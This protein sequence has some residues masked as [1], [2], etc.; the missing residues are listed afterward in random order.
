M[1][2]IATKDWIGRWGASVFSENISIFE[3]QFSSVLHKNTFCSVL[4]MEK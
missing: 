2:E 1:T 4:F 3:G